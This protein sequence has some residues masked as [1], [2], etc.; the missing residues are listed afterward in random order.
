MIVATRIWSYS[1]CMSW[2]VPYGPVFRTIPGP[3]GAQSVFSPFVDLEHQKSARAV[4]PLKR[5][6]FPVASRYLEK[7]IRKNSVDGDVVGKFS[8]IK[9]NMTQINYHKILIKGIEPIR[10][11]RLS[12]S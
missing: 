12:T 4:Q 1:F 10:M 11:S 3:R 9:P 7:K 2:V 6:P 8:K 5:K